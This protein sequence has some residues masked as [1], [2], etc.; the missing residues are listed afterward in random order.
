M[1][2]TPLGPTRVPSRSTTG[3]RRGTSPEQNVEH[4][5][6]SS[7]RTVVRAVRYSGL[8]VRLAESDGLRLLRRS[9][10]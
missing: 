1:S 7:T 2:E 4:S 6:D 9:E 10:L 5:W 3:P 8:N